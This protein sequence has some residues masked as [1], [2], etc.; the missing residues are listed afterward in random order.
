MKVVK[1]PRFNSHWSLKD[2]RFMYLTSLF[3]TKWKLHNKWLYP[4][5]ITVYIQGRESTYCYYTIR[6]SWNWEQGL[7][8]PA[9]ALCWGRATG[10][11]SKIRHLR[12]SGPP[13]AGK[14]SPR[15][16]RF[17]SCW[18]S[19]TG[20]LWVLKDWYNLEAGKKNKNLKVWEGKRNI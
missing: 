18:Y 19:T 7:V 9:P 10:V 11:M 5:I 6:S 15:L 12:V 3:F 16:S 4:D 2:N 1:D 17:S 14:N 20:I 8:R 13:P